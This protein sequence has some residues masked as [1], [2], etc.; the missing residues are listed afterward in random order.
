KNTF[1]NLDK[2][3]TGDVFIIVYQGYAYKYEVTGSEVVK[4]EEFGVT[5]ENATYDDVVLYTCTPLWTAAKRLLVHSKPVSF[6]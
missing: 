6:Y 3:E 1:Y 4:P 5:G 2:L